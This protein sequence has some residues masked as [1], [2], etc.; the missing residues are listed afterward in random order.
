MKET[1]TKI[2]F[3]N[4]LKTIGG[5]IVSV[6]YENNRVIFDFG[7]SYNPAEEFSAMVKT[8]GHVMVEDY[9]N[10]NKIPPIDGLYS[11]KDLR[12]LSNVISAEEDERN[13]AVL[14]SHLHLDHI[15]AMGLVSPN[16]PVYLTEDS[17]KLY[18]ALEEIGEGV[19]GERSYSSIEYDKVLKV[20]V[21]K[22]T[23]V[24]LDHD[25]L[26]ACSFFIET[27]DIKIV[28]SG[29]LR[30]HGRQPELTMDFVSKA[31][32]FMPNLLLMEGTMINGEKD[33]K[34]TKPSNELNG[35]N[36]ENQVKEMLTD[37]FEKAKGLVLVNASE[38][39]LERIADI[40]EAADAAGR[41]I[42]LEPATAYLISRII[43]SGNFIVYESE[44]LEAEL[45]KG[46]VAGWLSELLSAYET[47]S[48]KD[49][50][51]NPKK[52][53]VQ[54][55]FKNL[56]E[57]LDLN[58]KK[59]V[60]I[61]SNA[62]PLG[63]YDPDFQKLQEFLRRLKVD[64]EYIGT[65]GHAFHSHLK[66]IIDE[67]EPEILVPLHSFYPEKLYPESKLQFLP[68]YGVEYIV[69]DKKMIKLKIK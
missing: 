50:N 66:Y 60:Y 51:L 33:S 67:I 12:N 59:G 53:V 35:I 3:W 34:D 29:D 30:I 62:V 54:N 16:I 63:A 27:P 58:L 57:L 64:Y 4:G 17:L 68:D 8:R 14:I 22:V 15:G 56:M 23:A 36:T 10:L 65:P 21:I 55:S 46:N 1:N 37:K 32:N 5:T 19:P 18:E 7:L 26:G 52:Y 25:V 13:T 9:I 69:K 6:E 44:E 20:G 45:L 2:R 47:V 24:Q 40:V 31:H 43:D 38:R 61:H 28:Y 48:Y 49:I 41:K 39:N 11:R 42:V